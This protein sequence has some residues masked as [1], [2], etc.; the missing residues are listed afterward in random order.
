MAEFCVISSGGDYPKLD[1]LL[2]TPSPRWVTSGG[3]V[4]MRGKYPV[5]PLL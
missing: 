4:F 3:F 1:N 2:D 5:I